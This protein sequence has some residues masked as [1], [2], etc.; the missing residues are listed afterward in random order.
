VSARALAVS[1]AVTLG[2]VFLATAVY[3]IPLENALVLAPVFVIGAGA[4]AGLVVLWWKA[5]RDNLRRRG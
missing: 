4:V 1:L 5:A 3:D 2:L